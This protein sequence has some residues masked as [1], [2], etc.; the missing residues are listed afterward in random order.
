M[1]KKNKNNNINKQIT[2]HD[3]KDIE[4]SDIP[5]K[6]FKKSS[7][8]K[9]GHFHIIADE[10]DEKYISLGLTSDNPK[11]KR[12][13]KLYPV[14]ESNNVLGR[15][16]RSAEINDKEL[17]DSNNANF[18]VDIDT[19]NKAIEKAARKKA[20]YLENNAKKNRK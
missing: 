11:N 2:H 20:R 19:A 13:Q 10:V 1:S 14:Y 18:K 7:K 15:M 4:Y 17:F 3:R 12:N 16:H 6:R 8:G 5:I 9:G